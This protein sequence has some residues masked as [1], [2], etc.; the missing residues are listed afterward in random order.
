MKSMKTIKVEASKNYEVLIGG[1]I[2]PLAGELTAK[3]KKPG[4]A[5]IVSDGNVFP[6]YGETAVKSYK[7]AGFEVKSFVFEHGEQSKS[8]ETAV[9]LLEFMATEGL[10]RGDLAIALGGGVT[11]DLTGF[12]ASVY[13]RGIDYV[14]IPT[15]FLAA[16][17]SSVGGKTG[18]NLAAGKN[19]AGAFHQPA[20][21][22]CD[23]DTFATLPEEVFA[24]GAAEAI[25]YGCIADEKLFETLLNNDIKEN[26]ADVA[27]TCVKIKRGLVEE[28]EF[29]GGARRLLNFGH[30]AGHAIE[31][32]SGYKI[33]HGQAVAKGMYIMAKRCGDDAAA[34]I[35]R[36]LE[37]YKL[38]ANCPYPAE[39]LAQKALSDKK[40]N[41][42]EITIVLLNKIGE[43][44]LKKIAVGE[45]VNYFR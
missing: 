12:A 29:D 40:R 24:D 3:I 34:Q 30:T 35:L 17:D 15:T 13:L 26:I 23:V 44:Y 38:D 20:A 14:Q 18:V 16:I 6:L 1:G 45:L 8:M 25:K 28:D 39:A 4:K 7:N 21:V 41:G 19:L 32:L 43:A 5:I 36:A 11:G 2:L 9:R 42:G 22:F 27:E 10:S 37:K 31:A 33:S